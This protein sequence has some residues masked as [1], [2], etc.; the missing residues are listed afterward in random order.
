[1]KIV[2]HDIAVVSQVPNPTTVYQGG[3]V[4][5]AVTVRNEGT[6]TGSLTLRVY[7]YGDLEC[8]VGQEVVDLLPGES[9][10]LYFEW[11][12]ANIPPGTYYIDA[13]ALP[14]E[15]ELDTDDN[16]CTSLAAVTVRAAPIVGGTVQ[17]EKPAILYQTLLVAL[18]LAF[19]AIIAV[20]VVTRAKNSVRAR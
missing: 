5:I 3:I 19:T 6:E 16:A 17:I 13:R 2:V 9:R 11:Y 7:Y 15:G 12:T 4:T 18:A 8:C 1:M 14:V 20:G 10:T